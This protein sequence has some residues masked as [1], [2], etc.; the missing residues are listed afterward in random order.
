M[1]RTKYAAR[2]PNC[3]SCRLYNAV[4]GKDLI[5]DGVSVQ[6]L[7]ADVHASVLIS[8]RFTNAMETTVSAVYT[9]GIMTDAAVC[10]FEMVRQDGTRV[11]GIVK[12]KDEAKKEY[13]KAISDGK[14]ASLGQQETAD[15]ARLIVAKIVSLVTAP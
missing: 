11:E 10:R 15:G 12:E 4:T 14:T 1:A 6:V 5:L 3:P 7:I 8:Q 2:T 9:F 13:E